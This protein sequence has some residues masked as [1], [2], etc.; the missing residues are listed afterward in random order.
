[1]TNPDDKLREIVSKLTDGDHEH[2]AKLLLDM[3]DARE[4]PVVGDEARALH[5]WELIDRVFQ[6]LTPQQRDEAIVKME[7]WLKERK[8]A[9]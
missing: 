7:E 9:D 4:A 8:Q 2:S 6:G 1:M 5:A 3:V